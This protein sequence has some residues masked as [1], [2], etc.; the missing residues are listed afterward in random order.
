MGC[1]EYSL[2]NAL[3]VA[4]RRIGSMGQEMK[5]VKAGGDGKH[6]E[7]MENCSAQLTAVSAD[8]SLPAACHKRNESQRVISRSDVLLCRGCCCAG[9]CA[10][11]V[12]LCVCVSITKVQFGATKSVNRKST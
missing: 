5:E 10:A 3:T 4:T 1:W 12:R 2:A 8:T 9:M 11:G 7:N 6:M